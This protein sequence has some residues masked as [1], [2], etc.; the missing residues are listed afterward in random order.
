MRTDQ[1]QNIPTNDTSMKNDIL[2]HIDNPHQLE[3]LYRENKSA[4]RQEFAILYPELRENKI[5]DFWY[6]RLNYE[7]EDVSWGTARD[8]TFVI[9]A[10]LV[11]GLIAKLPGLLNLNEEFFYQRNIGFIVFP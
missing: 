10:S 3:K 1:I 11:A 7:S 4:F 6:E 9:I 8:I 2:L 5:A